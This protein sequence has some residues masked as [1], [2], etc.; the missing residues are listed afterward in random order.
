M[1]TVSREEIFKTLALLHRKV[2]IIMGAMPR[3]VSRTLVVNEIGETELANAIKLGIIKPGRGRSRNS[4]M[5]IERSEY[6]R[7]LEYMKA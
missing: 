2:D 5:L 7:Y 4:R 1:E 6:E 3:F